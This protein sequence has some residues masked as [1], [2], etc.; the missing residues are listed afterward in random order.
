[1]N[2]SSTEYFCEL[3]TYSKDEFR[4]C[5]FLLKASNLQIAERLDFANYSHM[6]AITFFGSS[7][8]ICIRNNNLDENRVKSRL[9]KCTMQSANAKEH[10]FAERIQKKC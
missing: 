5:A 4:T 6:H 9:L 1:M 8:L 10:Q 2:R 3:K 7:K